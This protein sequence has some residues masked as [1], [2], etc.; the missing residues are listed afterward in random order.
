MRT[1]LNDNTLGFCTFKSKDGTRSRPS[2]TPSRFITDLD[3]ADD[4]MLLSDCEHK[5]QLMLTSIENMASKVG[6]KINK[7]KTEFILIGNWDN[8]NDIK[9]N[10]SSGNI[11]LVEDYKYLGSWIM[12]SAKDFE[13]RKALAWKACMKLK[14][15]WK[16]DIIPK[17]LKLN[18]FKACVESILLYNAVT[19]TMNITLEKKLDGCYTRLLRY[20]LGYT[21]SDKIK[22]EILYKDIEKISIRLKRRKFKFIENC[23][24]SKSQP[25]SEL[26]FFD[27]SIMV[28][29]GKLNKGNRSNYI[30]ILLEEINELEE[31][32]INVDGIK[33]LLS[34]NKYWKNLI[35]KI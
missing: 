5:A 11:K 31:S 1:A 26:L 16:S 30:K 8:K 10:L 21:W 3:F 14:K 12:N 17:N 20:A 32:I 18:I 34:N 4:I 23:F 22:N 2:K 7:S 24:N 33:N 35:L 6:L 15:I 28:G 29:N 9:I 19:W 25:I 13:V 27:H